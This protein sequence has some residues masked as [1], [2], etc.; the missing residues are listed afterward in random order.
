MNSTDATACLET[1]DHAAEENS[2]VS[3]FALAF[4]RCRGEVDR[5]LDEL[6]E[7]PQEARRVITRDLS[8]S[9]THEQLR[10]IDTMA[11][12]TAGKG[13]L[14]DRLRSILALRLVAMHALEELLDRPR[15]D[16]T[17]IRR[18]VDLMPSLVTAIHNMEETL[19]AELKHLYPADRDCLLQ[20]AHAMLPSK[21]WITTGDVLAPRLELLALAAQ[22]GDLGKAAPLLTDDEIALIRSALAS[23]EDDT[24]ETSRI[25]IN[26]LTLRTIIEDDVAS[27]E[28]SREHSSG[29]PLASGADERIRAR[30]SRDKIA[31]DFLTAQ[32]QARQETAQV[33]GLQGFADE[34]SRVKGELF[35]SYLELAP[36]LRESGCR[37]SGGISP[38]DAPASPSGP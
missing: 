23:G 12:R 16:G 25:C 18:A 27:W 9:P 6:P 38:P 37:L 1:T 22:Q 10:M 17:R 14:R 30:L 19:R 34:L 21:E 8:F 2:A 35:A 32:I 26:A 4:T 36:A 5:V 28:V 11:H 3:R 33:A 7:I 31:Y 24:E 15:I 20:T 29:H 13:V